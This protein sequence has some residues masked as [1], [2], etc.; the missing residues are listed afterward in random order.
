MNAD[1]SRDPPD[2]EVRVKGVWLMSD[3][4]TGE[5]RVIHKS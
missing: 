3:L 2:I 5:G 4:G 1:V